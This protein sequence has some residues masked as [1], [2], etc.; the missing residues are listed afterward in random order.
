M[1]LW[2]L[3]AVA[4]GGVPADLLLTNAN[5]INTFTA[6]IERS[7]VAIFGGRIAGIGDYQVG[8]EIIN[9]EGKYLSPALIDGHVHPESSMLHIRGYAEAVVPRGISAIVTDFHEI[10]NVRGLRGVRYMLN[11]AKPLPLDVYLMVP[12]CVPSTDLETPGARLGPRDIKSALSWENSIGL[13]EVMN[14]PRVLTAD[15]LIQHKILFASEKL[16]DGHAPGLRGKDLNAYIACGIRS[17][18]ECTSLDEAKEKIN[19]GMYVMIRE[20]SSENNLSELLPLVNDKTYKRCIFVVDDRTCDDLVNEGDVDAVVRKA[21]KLGLDPIRAIQLATINPAEYFRFRGLGAISPGYFANLAVVSDLASFEVEKVFYHGELVAENGQPLF[22]PTVRVDN[23]DITHTMNI[24]DFDIESLRL[25]AYTGESVT[26]EIIP[27]QIITKRVE[28][29]VKVKDGL[30][31]PDID[32]DILKLVVIERHKSTGNISV[33]LV[34]GFGLKMG[35]LGSSFAHDSHNIIVV[36][37]NDQD[38]YITVKE[39]E[40]LQGGLVVTANGEIRGALPLPVA[41]LMSNEQPQTVVNKLEKLKM[42]ARELGC[43]PSHPFA[44]L[45]LLSLPVVPE[46]RLTDRGLVDVID[47]TLIN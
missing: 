41:G 9:L 31:Q 8:K 15:E 10:A 27:D 17:D 42:L 24:K 34:T 36:G 40:R 33:G 43:K 2:E 13:G 46:L 20:G 4:R 7:N 14:F 45:S 18:H 3:I 11:C 19:R 5:V 39:I 32:Q 22:P 29:R 23:E 30:V 26:I 28:K 37:T 1:S 47:F 44:T 21:I 12:S 16:I 35:A 38:I 25:P 6:E